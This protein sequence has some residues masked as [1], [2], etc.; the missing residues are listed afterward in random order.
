QGE[1]IP[2]G[3]VRH[4]REDWTIGR[5]RSA[6]RGHPY[7]RFPVVG[8]NGRVVGVVSAID[9]YTHESIQGESDGISGLMHEAAEVSPKMS[10]EQ[11]LRVLSK[12][13]GHLAVVRSRS[14]DMGIVTRKDLVEPLVGELEEW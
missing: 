1:M 6:V 10:V 2:I 12:S 14:R 4:L 11:A 8:R 9:L 7:S 13:G 3:L 5:A